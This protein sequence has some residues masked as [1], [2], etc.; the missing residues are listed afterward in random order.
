MEGEWAVLDFRPYNPGIQ[1]G[2]AYTMI[3]LNMIQGFSRAACKK[4]KRAIVLSK[5]LQWLPFFEKKLFTVIV[6]KANIILER[7]HKKH[8][9]AWTSGDFY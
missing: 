1:A 2:K 3:R 6:F 8:V 4:F 9:L 7:C 5:R